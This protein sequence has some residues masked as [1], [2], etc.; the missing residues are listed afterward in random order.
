MEDLPV[1][2]QEARFSS[3]ICPG[4]FALFSSKMLAR[5]R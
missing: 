5:V 2:G 1:A 4:E 3:V